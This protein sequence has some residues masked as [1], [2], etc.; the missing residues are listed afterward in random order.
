MQP[1]DQP[2]PE[3]ATATEDLRRALDASEGGAFWLRRVLILVVAGLAV[4]G[5]FVWRARHRPP[6]P[7]RY[8]TATTTMGDV[9]ESIQATGTVQP[10]LQVNI[11]AQT[12]GR[13]TK[14]LVDYNS[15]VKKGDV[16]AEIDATTYDA[17]VAQAQASLSAASAQ[18]QSAKAQA[19]SAKVAFDRVKNLFSQNLTS[20]SELDAAEGH[21]RVAQAQAAAASAQTG[22]T[23]AVLTQS[24]VNVS[25]TRLLS[26]VDGLV[27]SRAIDPGA[28]V[29]ASYQAPVLFVIARDLRRMRIVA[30]VDEAD[31][32]RIVEGM[33]AQAVVDA[34]PRDTF[35][36]TVQQLRYAPNSVQGVV[37]YS[38]IIE[39]ENKGEKL[40]PGMTATVTV[41]AHAARG[42]L[43]VPNS[44]LRFRPGGD[45]VTAAEVLPE[46]LGKVYIHKRE[47]GEEQ[48]EAKTIQ[49]GITDGAYTE[50]KGDL[51]EGAKVV[52]DEYD[53]G[54]KEKKL[55]LF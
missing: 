29:V 48:I 41:Q 40:R 45:G 36:G 50:V 24:K 18:A 55:K 44:A 9:Y 14:V 3:L 26:P 7:P 1:A 51:T 35:R 23:H 43:R 49:V 15:I 27:V 53:V 34:F 16:L 31:V 17:Q 5:G 42:V 21:L 4:A 2:I 38:A 32:G 11:G 8:A 19:D 47:R 12:N 6:P 13:V 10:V 30:D 22:A 39:V 46:G 28:T 52:T 25:L 37:S 54:D 33:E 20:K